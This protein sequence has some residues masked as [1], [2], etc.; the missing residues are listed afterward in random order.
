MKATSFLCSILLSMNLA[1]APDYPAIVPRL[2][3]TI[4]AEMTEWGIGGLSVALIDG[5]ET[6]HSAGY[7]EAKRNSVFRV[8]SVSKLL[9]AIAVMQLVEEG[10]LDL[11]APLPTDLLPLNPFPGEGAVTLRQLLCHRSGLQREVPVGG[12]FDPSQPG[13][14]A[15]IGSLRS[16]V[17]VTQ[18]GEKTRYSNVGAS[19]AG[20]LVERASG[21]DFA[22]PTSGN[23]SS[24]PS[25]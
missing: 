2:D 16:G 24:A 7:G 20:F 6:V 14:A 11:D 22:A 23:E 17:L 15:T 25:G 13:L 5:S 3:A 18:P 4:R 8:G 1:A 12:Y 10:K 19:L 21:T 9:N